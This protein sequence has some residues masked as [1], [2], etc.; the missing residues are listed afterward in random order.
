M[1]IHP[2]TLK[3]LVSQHFVQQIVKANNKEIIKAMLALNSL[4]PSD[5][6]MRQ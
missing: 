2:W 4:R 5:A 6:Y 3:S 1:N